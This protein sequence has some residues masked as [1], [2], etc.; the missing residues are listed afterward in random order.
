MVKTIANCFLYLSLILLF[1]NKLVAQ[2]KEQDAPSDIRIAWDY[3]SLEQLAPQGGYPRLLRLSSGQLMAVYENRKGD[4]HLIRSADNGESWSSPEILFSSFIFDE[5]S[6]DGGSVQVNAANPEL[7][8]LAN[9]TILFVCNYRPRKDNIAPFSIA[10]KRLENDQNWS[11]TAII[12]EGGKTFTDGCW[13][14][15]L[16]ELAGGEVHLYFANE[17]PYRETQEQEISV[18][19]SI[20]NGQTWSSPQMASYRQGHRDGM[21][22]AT[23]AENKIYLAIEDNKIGQFKPYIIQTFAQKSWEKPILAHSKNRWYA[24]EKKE[25]DSVYMGAPYLIK[26]P[27]GQ[28]LLSYQTNRNRDH[29]WEYS[30]MEVAVSNRQAKAFS[31]IT[32][33]FPVALNKEAKWNSLAN[34]DASTVVALS[35][36][37]FKSEKIAPWMIK[38]YIIPSK[39]NLKN[40]NDSVKL[41]VGAKSEAHLHAVIRRTKR[42]LFIELKGKQL[43]DSSN[44]AVKTFNILLHNA[45]GTEKIALEPNGHLQTYGDRLADREKVEIAYQY[46][47]SKEKENLNYTFNIP[48]AKINESILL[49]LTLNFINQSGEITKEFLANMEEDNPNTWIQIEL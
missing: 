6:T 18:L 25:D 32:Q 1:E 10:I 11:E 13:E 26:L 42:S 33:P 4:I 38:G 30:T 20:D 29:N 44:Q 27:Q 47:Y 39:V 40:E 41:F 23:L 37:N 46:T 3:S 16:L 21:P 15:S 17:S 36:S 45:N 19:K 35:S 48:I 2:N 5:E 28:F 22:V 49:G 34:W 43:I 24:L 12:Y 8:E 31:N 14:P 7:K 9:G